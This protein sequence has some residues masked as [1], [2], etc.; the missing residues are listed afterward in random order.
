[1]PFLPAWLKSQAYSEETIGLI[2]ASSYLFRF[3]GGLLFSSI[4]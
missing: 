3:V 4:S 2:I 1:M